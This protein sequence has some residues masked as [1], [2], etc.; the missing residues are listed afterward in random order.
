MTRLVIVL[1]VSMLAVMAC[2]FG[3]FGFSGRGILT[4]A[5]AQ[6]LRP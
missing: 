3:S 1:L 6:E 2:G 4:A 5:M